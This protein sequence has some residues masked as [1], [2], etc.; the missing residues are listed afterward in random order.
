MR[1]P[2]SP[3]T[4][5]DESKDVRLVFR[6]ETCKDRIVGVCF[7]RGKKFGFETFGVRLWACAKVHFLDV[8]RRN[9]Y[10]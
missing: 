7:F 2:N 4:L 9:E 6:L 1:S 5:V 3:V 10:T 8:T